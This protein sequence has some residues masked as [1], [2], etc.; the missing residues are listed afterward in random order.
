MPLISVL[1]R[2]RQMDLCEFEASM[3][4]KISPRTARAVT[5]RNSVSNKPYIYVFIPIYMFSIP[6][7]T[8]KRHQIPLQMV[9]SH[10]VVAGI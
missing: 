7:L 6:L 10:H 5:Q 8:Q 2:Q 1:R 9:V 4:Y 3:V